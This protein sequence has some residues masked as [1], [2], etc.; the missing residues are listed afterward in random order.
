MNRPKSGRFS[1][2][3]YICL[4][5]EQR[6]S[7]GAGLL[8]YKPDSTGIPRSARN[9]RIIVGQGVFAEPTAVYNTHISA[10]NLGV[11]RI[12][13]SI[14]VGIGIIPDYS[15]TKA[16]MDGATISLLLDLERKRNRP[17]RIGPTNQGKES[18]Y[19]ASH[20]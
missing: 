13:I 12:P 14:D 1:K 6:F 19:H 17:F 9:C 2:R 4:T 18:N 11:K 3:P 8:F 5:Q 16:E 15:A 7:K 20:V 10:T